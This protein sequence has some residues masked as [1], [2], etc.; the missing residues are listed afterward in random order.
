MIPCSTCNNVCVQKERDEVDRIVEE[1]A[2]ERP[3]LDLAPLH[4]FSR[5]IRLTKHL[6]K[7][8]TLAFDRTGLNTWEFDVLAVLRR[9]G[10]PYRQ[11]PKTLVRETLV[12]SGT[13]TSRID[14]M[15]ERELVRRLPD[16]GDGRGVLVEITPVGLTLVDAAITRL[17]DAEEHLLDGLNREDRESLSNLLRKLALSL[18]E[19]S[20]N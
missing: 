18:G 13:I 12:S 16:P 5:L 3:D 6:A 1:W 20:A 15:V 17:T 7:A 10:A 4:I 8:R 11:T 2:E 9:G 14:R 19:A